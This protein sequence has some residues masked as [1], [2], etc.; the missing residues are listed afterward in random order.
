MPWPCFMIE[1]TDRCRRWLR[2]YV[3]TGE[4]R[5]CAGGYHQA[6]TAIDDGPELR[7][8]EGY[9]R[10]EPSEW[11]R[12][13]PRWPV[14]CACGY[15]FT[16][17]DAWQLFCRSIYRRADTDEE[18]TIE[19]APAGAMWDA[20]WMGEPW[21]GQDGRSLCVKLPPGGQADYW[22]ID[23]PSRDGGH[24]TRTGTPPLI[25][26]RPSILTPKYHG[27]LTDGVLSDDLDGRQYGDG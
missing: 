4:G 10:T 5:D 14:Q 2:R 12:D 13:D 3:H 27:W 8:A 26:A 15:R 7:A 18:M 23:G 20:F 17:V 22:H 1:P 9:R 25:T 11:P 21:R 6:M 19:D 16:A 24:W